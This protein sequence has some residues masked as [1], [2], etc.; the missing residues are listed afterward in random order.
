MQ[1]E[2]KSFKTTSFRVTVI[3]PGLMVILFLVLKI[4]RMKNTT[5]N[6]TFSLCVA[7]HHWGDLVAVFPLTLFRVV[8]LN[9][10]LEHCGI[11]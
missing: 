2:T 7:A 9:F 1:V 4:S 11:T 3:K 10:L 6:H 8:V 5:W